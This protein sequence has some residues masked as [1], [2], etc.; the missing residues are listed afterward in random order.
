MKK[1]IISIILYLTAIGII[2]IAIE[3]SDILIGMLGIA[4]IVATLIW[5]EVKG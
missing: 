1:V 5:Q 2:N 4:L 3:A